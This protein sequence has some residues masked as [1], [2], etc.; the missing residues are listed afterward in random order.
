[1]KSFR[2]RL[3]IYFCLVSLSSA[4][5]ATRPLA[6][7]RNWDCG[8]ILNTRRPSFLLLQPEDN[9]NDASSSTDFD[10][11][12]RRIMGSLATLGVLETSFLTYTKL[13][14]PS[15]DIC[16]TAGDCASVLNGPY[17][18]IPFTNIPLATLGLVAYLT[19]AYLALE[20]VVMLERDDSNETN[21]L[22]LLGDDDCHGN[23]FRLFIVTYLWYTAYIMLVLFGIGHF[24]HFSRIVCMVGRMLC[25]VETTMARNGECKREWQVLL[26]RH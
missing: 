10:P 9:R 3:T 18:T 24:E 8:S 22:A 21:R 25:L 13:A 1:M 5:T 26:P 16:G 17:S 6:I 7:H 11:E 2:I 4:F 19:T 20:P 23:L 15:L 14:N 12:V